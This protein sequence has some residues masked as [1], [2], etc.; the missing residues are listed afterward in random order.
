MDKFEEELLAVAIE[1]IL[2]YLETPPTTTPNQ[3][4]VT[5]RE[6]YDEYRELKR[7]D[8]GWIDEMRDNQKYH[9]TVPLENFVKA[10]DTNFEERAVKAVQNARRRDPNLFK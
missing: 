6:C 10:L 2:V 8:K 4:L 5:A 7:G 3:H 9:T 1:E